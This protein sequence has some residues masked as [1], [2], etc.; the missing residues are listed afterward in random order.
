MENIKI[1]IGEREIPLRFRMPEFLEIEE[2]V[3]NLGNIRELILNGK[4]RL[5]N[6]IKV[7]RILGNAGLK[8]AGETADLTDEWLTENM[9][10]YKV[11]EYQLAVLACLSEE[12]KSEAA[13]EES[14]SHERDLVLEEIQEKKEPVNSH[15]GA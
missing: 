9:S 3:G 5:R 6:M 14:E 8:A 7:T 10:P 12:S 1:T 4:Q 13:V 11:M 15:T 2:N